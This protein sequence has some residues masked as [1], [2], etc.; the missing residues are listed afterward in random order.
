[1]DDPKKVAKLME[2]PPTPPVSTMTLQMKTVVNPKTHQHEVVALAACVHPDV[3]LD[4]ATEE[5]RRGMKWFV[6]VR[7]LGTSA[8]SQHMARLPHDLKPVLNACNMGKVQQMPNERALLSCLLQR[9]HSEDPDV[10]VSHNL[11]G[12]DFDVLLT[13]CVEHKLGLWSRL[14]RLHR[15]KMPILRSKTGNFREKLIAEACTGRILCDTYLSARDLLREENYS[16]THLAKVQ[17]GE[18]RQDIDPMDVPEFFS[19]SNHMTNLIKQMCQ[20]AGMVQR[21]L[22]KLQV[23]PLTKQLTGIAGNLWS[24]TAKGG[25]RAQRVEFLLLHEFHRLKYITPDKQTWAIKEHKAAA[26]GLSSAAPQK[27]G[28]GKPQYAGGLVLEPKKGLYE[29]YIL[30]LDF[31]SLY[32]SIIQEYNLCFTTMD[33]APYIP[34]ANTGGAGGV[35]GSAAMDVD[36]TDG[37]AA[38]L[39]A[40]GTVTL[41]PLPDEALEPGVVPK[42]IKSIIARR[43]TVKGILKQE[44]DPAKRQTLDIKQ[45]AL[46]LTANSLYGCLGFSNSRF[47]AKPIAAQ[48]TAMG[49]ETLQR[50]VDLAETQLNLEVIYGDTDSIMINTNSTDLAVVKDLGNQVKKEV[51]KLYKTLELEMDGI[52]KSM[53]LLKKKKYAALVVEEDSKTGEVSYS[54]ETKGLDLVRRDWCRLSKNLG[55]FVLDHI[56]SGE[57]REIVVSQIHAKMDKVSKKMRAFEVPIDEFVVTKG[58][59]KSVKDYP[60]AK[61]QPHLQVALAMLKEGKTVNT[62]DHIPYVICVKPDSDEHEPASFAQRAYH[63]DAVARSQGALQGK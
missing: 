4:C 36:V 27:K 50:T 35:G 49:R 9:I 8:G 61:S 33:W 17:L 63:P 20:S 25:D 42:V 12:F 23:L 31:N 38:T 18:S 28:R 5:N 24:K 32:P 55:Q 26:A 22:F 52:F 37:G 59:N 58:M 15:N 51:N 6:A 46:K 56:L 57:S 34:K 1:M 11:F 10:L 53:L 14:G 44:K 16:L 45:K 41:P 2:Q 39:E 30:L 29:T 21:L 54:K 19:T 13:R 47:F 48:V 43:V 7:P 40:D 60:D 62:G 3:N